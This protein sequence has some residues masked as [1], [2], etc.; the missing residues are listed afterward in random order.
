[1]AYA[2][3]NNVEIGNLAKIA[4]VA[5]AAAGKICSV[6]GG[7]AAAATGPSPYSKSLLLD[8]T[9]DGIRAYGNNESE[10]GGYANTYAE[11]ADFTAPMLDNNAPFTWDV[12]FRFDNS[13]NRFDSYWGNYNIST[14][15]GLLVQCYTWGTN[16]YVNVK[17]HRKTDSGGGGTTAGGNL[18]HRH[19]F[20]GVNT[21]HFTGSESQGFWHKLTICKGTGDSLDATNFQV[22]MNGYLCTDNGGSIYINNN[23][24]TEAWTTDYGPIPE[25]TW[26]P[27]SNN[28]GYRWFDFIY[29]GGDVAVG[30]MSWYDKALSEAEVNDIYDGGARLGG[31]PDQDKI[32][33]IDPTTASTAS[34]LLHYYYY[35]TVIDG[36]GSETN[37]DDKITA[38]EDPELT[39]LNCTI[40]DVASSTTPQVALFLAPKPPGAT[41]AGETVVLTCVG[42]QPGVSTVRWYSDSGHTSLLNTGETYSHTVPAAGD[43]TLYL[44]DTNSGG[45][46]QF[47]EFEYTSYA[48]AGHE[49]Y[50]YNMGIP[51]KNNGSAPSNYNDKISAALFDNDG[52]FSFSLWFKQEADNSFNGNMYTMVAGSNYDIRIHGNSNYPRTAWKFNGVTTYVT[53]YGGR[54]NWAFGKWHVLTC[55][56]DPLTGTVSYWTDGAAMTPV[57]DSNMEGSFTATGDF[58]FNI[59]TNFGAIAQVALYDDVLTDAEAIAIQG[60]AGE[61]GAG[62]T[63]DIANL[64]GSKDKLIEYWKFD[65]AHDNDSADTYVGEILGKVFPLTNNVASNSQRRVIDR[66]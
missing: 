50:A 22:Y 19:Y 23:D 20:N 31:S 61:G 18:Y 47:V 5:K 49:N 51:E 7:A 13:A 63:Q 66:P 11:M 60:G 45:I 21:N 44:K 54:D 26:V 14:N 52:K 33:N 57:T 9:N 64:T 65:E 6:E 43:I 16:A 53:T 32:M 17:W 10:S 58:Y 59:S 38:G 2:K 8:T 3:I 4:N 40:A 36:T 46:D 25:A 1:M 24:G 29:Q 42:S 30:S 62:F 37:I 55:S 15:G 41:Y 39:L 12:E 34:N 28:Q 35:D 27:A 56:H 48:T